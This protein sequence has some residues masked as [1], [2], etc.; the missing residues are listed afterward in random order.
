MKT[1]GNSH[2]HSHREADSNH[3]PGKSSGYVIFSGQSYLDQKRW[4]D[5]RSKESSYTHSN[6]DGKY[7][8]YNISGLEV[9]KPL[10]IL[11]NKET[12]KVEYI[13]ISY[14]EKEEYPGYDAYKM[15]YHEY[16]AKQFKA[17]LERR[18]KLKNAKGREREKLLEE[19]AREG[20]SYPPKSDSSFDEFMDKIKTD[21]ESIRE[22][23]YYELSL[24]QIL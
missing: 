11:K 3:N 24:K 19:L 23:I 18:N 6:R 17:C 9:E 5:I 14:K 21:K 1:R 15:H 13:L 7:V 20:I 2:S 22:I 16:V 4:D 8:S 12:G 10:S